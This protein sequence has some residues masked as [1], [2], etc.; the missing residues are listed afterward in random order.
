MHSNN[1][2]YISILCLFLSLKAT[3]DSEPLV[4]LNGESASDIVIPSIFFIAESGGNAERAS[5]WINIALKQYYDEAHAFIRKGI[6]DAKSYGHD[7]VWD[8]AF[9]S[10]L[11]ENSRKGILPRWVENIFIVRKE[12]EVIVAFYVRN[13]G[14]QEMNVTN[15]T[16]CEETGAWK[17]KELH[18]L[19]MNVYPAY[20]CVVDPKTKIILSHKYKPVIYSNMYEFLAEDGILTDYAPQEGFI[21]PIN[22]TK[23][24]PKGS[25]RILGPAKKKEERTERIKGGK[26]DDS[27][28][29][30]E[31]HSPAAARRN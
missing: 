23:D 31:P 8:K 25:G 17:H 14:W 15:G 28:N 18:V 3:A 4:P 7:A 12:S 2:I 11:E 6:S 10:E 27:G 29:A 22:P 21:T 19:G 24:K 13:G 16:Q 9:L 1:L 26:D 20:I 30:N 5:I